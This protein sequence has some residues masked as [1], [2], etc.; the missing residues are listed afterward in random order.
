MT[1]R[2]LITRLEAE[3]FTLSLKLR[4]EG[5][6]DAA[7]PAELLELLKTHKH[8]LISHLAT[9][10]PLL[11]QLREEGVLFHARE[12]KLQP[13]AEEHAAYAE[14]LEQ[15]TA[16]Y[17]SWAAKLLDTYPYVMLESPLPWR[18]GYVI[19]SHF[20]DVGK[21]AERRIWL[22]AWAMW[23]VL[24]YQNEVLEAWGEDAYRQLER[25]EMETAA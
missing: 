6:K 10:T 3:G 22:D 2:D 12:G 1:P 9:A 7:P 23:G 17:L 4:V 21:L 20:K 25:R 11:C 15:E 13:K 24:T 16:R 14:V 18:E 5:E 8:N 19:A